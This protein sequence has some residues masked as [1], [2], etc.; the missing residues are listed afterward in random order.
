MT[1]KTKAYGA[2]ISICLVWGTTY[3]A[4]RIGVDTLPPFLFAGFRWI[5]AGLFLLSI[6]KFRGYKLP[7]KSDLIR[8]GIVGILLLG[9]GNGLVVFAEQW[10]PSGLTAL[11]IT[12]MPFWIVG[13]EALVPSGPKL[14]KLIFTG[15]F[16]GFSGLLLIFRDNL[17]NLLN[18]E[19]VTGIAALLF[20]MICWAA[21][22]VF[23]KYKK[24]STHP[25][26]GASVQ[27]LIAGVAQTSVG[28]LAGELPEFVFNQSNFLAFMY[29]VIVGSI[30]GYAFYIYAL[31]HLPVSLVSTYAYVNPVI[32]LFLGWLILDEP[33]T[34]LVIVSAVVIL[35]GVGL[36]KAGSRKLIN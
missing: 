21:G 15:L 10:I 6:M 13:I 14:N 8:L 36:V 16:L 12:T 26:M 24:V 7:P 20:G 23:S 30:F 25:M 11:L 34:I 35:T 5:I 4:I 27:M 29:L 9:F 17:G 28:L 3:L 1:E 22:S 2:W 19:Y 18:P 32:A 31:T 33:L